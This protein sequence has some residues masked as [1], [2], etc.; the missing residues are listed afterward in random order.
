MARNATITYQTAAQFEEAMWQ[1][2]R[3]ARASEPDDPRLKTIDTMWDTAEECRRS[4]DA[5]LSATA[6]NETAV[7][8]SASIAMLK[9]QAAQTQLDA[10]A[11]LRKWYSAY[12]RG[13]QTDRRGG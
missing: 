13:K 11:A 12:W 4:Y 3:S 8:P 6:D 2:F 9:K 5:G 1:A 10:D 7:S